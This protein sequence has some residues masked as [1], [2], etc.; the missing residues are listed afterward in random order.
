MEGR[1][2]SVTGKVSYCVSLSTCWW[3][4]YFS[5]G[6][7]LGI[8]FY[9][10]INLI[11]VRHD[12]VSLSYVGSTDWESASLVSERQIG[13]E[14]TLHCVSFSCVTLLEHRIITIFGWIYWSHVFVDIGGCLT[15]SFNSVKIQFLGY[16]IKLR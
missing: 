8:V 9:E 14:F 13:V 2:V 4:H 10:P 11:D 6:G 5:D 15:D 3:K 16:P 1:K 12:E 7:L